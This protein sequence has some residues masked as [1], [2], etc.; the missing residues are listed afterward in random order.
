MENENNDRNSLGFRI[1][2]KPLIINGSLT[3]IFR[4][5]LPKYKKLYPIGELVSAR[6]IKHPGDEKNKI[7][8]LY[9]DDKLFVRIKSINSVRI[10]ELKPEDFIGSSPDVHDQ[11]SLAYH[12]GLIYNEA[13][14]VF[15]P[16]T[17]IIKIKFSY[18]KITKII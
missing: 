13:A 1:V 15:G 17:K 11:E 4:P 5:N 2:Y 14:D 12:L 10:K 3:T 18:E 9:T 16:E 6:I 8:P 7:V